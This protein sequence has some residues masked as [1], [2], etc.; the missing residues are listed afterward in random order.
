MGFLVVIVTMWIVVISVCIPICIIEG[1]KPSVCIAWGVFLPITLS[2][3][4]VK[5]GIKGIID[6]YKGE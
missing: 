6:V 3:F 1:V 2:I 4:I 5:N